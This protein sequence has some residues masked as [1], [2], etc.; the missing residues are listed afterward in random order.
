MSFLRYALLLAGTALISGCG[1]NMTC[2]EPQPY[3]A[4][5]QGVRIAAPEGMDDLQSFKELKV[6]EASPQQAMPEG[7]P[8]LELPP[9]LRGN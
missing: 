7:S 5:H 6:P 8:C 1:N 9:A 3:Q 2:D 4:S